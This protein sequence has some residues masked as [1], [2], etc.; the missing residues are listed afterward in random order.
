V[1]A[2]S[3]CAPAKLIYFAAAQYRTCSTQRGFPTLGDADRRLFPNRQPSE[4]QVTETQRDSDLAQLLLINQAEDLP[5][6][7][8]MESQAQDQT[9][10][11]TNV[12]L[13]L[14]SHTI[15]GVCEAIGEDF[16]FNPVLL[17]IPLAASVIWQP[18]FALGVYFALGAVVLVSRLLFPARKTAAA[19]VQPQAEAA[20]AEAELAQAA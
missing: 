17:R 3:R 1:V 10:D 9:P 4:W 20:N 12:A 11:Q 16:G 15:L 5:T 6:E 19:Q 8:N 18:L 2:E 13:P 14:R 7:L